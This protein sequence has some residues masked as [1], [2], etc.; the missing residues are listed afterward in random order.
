MALPY[1]TTEPA[2][3]V[4]QFYVAGAD[5]TY[6]LDV[7]GVVPVSQFKEVESKVVGT[8]AKLKEFR[9]NNIALRKELET[10]SG[11]GVNIEALLETHVAELKGNYA[12]QIQTLSE[13]NKQLNE[14]LERVVL[15][16]GV[17]E[18]AIKYGVLESALPDVLSRAKDTFVVKDGKPVP[19]DKLIDK[20][21]NP[22][23]VTNWIQSLA[24]QAPHLFAQ[25]RGSGA[26]KTVRGG[27]QPVERT[28][29]EKI[30]AG[31]A[32]RQK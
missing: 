26:Q 17:K 8:E 25:S 12:T 30:A 29:A 28:P 27:Q 32:A 24:E 18:A 14:H 11:T 2:E 9:D 7:E 4:K 15:S 31:L 16:D 1:Q 3:E 10:K 6:V 22:M 20:E 5:G 19:K 21:G 13:Q 23:G